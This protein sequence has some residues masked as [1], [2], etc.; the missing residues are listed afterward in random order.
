[1]LSYHKLFINPVANTRVKCALYI[2]VLTLIVLML[3]AGCNK[4]D[5]KPEPEPTVNLA[6]D[7]LTATKKH[8]VVW[9]EIT[10]R[11]YATGDNLD[12]KWETSSGS[13]L[14]ID[15]VTVRYW[16]CPSC[17][18]ENIIQCSVSN[19]FGTLSDTIVVQVDP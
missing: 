6:L 10:V 8:I 11:V 2:P 14:P 5:E 17:V 16:G 7:S 12:Y 3:S 15:S 9:E 19:E 13:M 4:Q 1:M 18:G